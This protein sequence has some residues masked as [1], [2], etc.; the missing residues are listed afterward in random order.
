[1]SVTASALRNSAWLA[2]VDEGT[3]ASENSKLE[4]AE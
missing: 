1:M 4:D 2:D 3:W